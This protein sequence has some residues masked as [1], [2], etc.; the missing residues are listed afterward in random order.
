MGMGT[1]SLYQYFPSKNAIYDEVF[2]RGWRELEAHMRAFDQAAGPVTCAQEARALLRHG[3]DTFVEWALEHPM[4]AQLMFWRPV[5]GFT[6]SPAAYLA[7]VS[8][9]D[10]TRSTLTRFVHAGWLRPDA[11]GAAAVRAH[12]VLIAG[13]ISQQLSNEPT[14]NFHD[15]SFT[16]LIPLLTRMFFDAYATGDRHAAAQRISA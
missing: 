8:L 12:T 14:T 15:G 2:A 11:A 16:Q 9:L 6:P 3:A 7:A 10:L 4:Q 13:V 1:P 5:P